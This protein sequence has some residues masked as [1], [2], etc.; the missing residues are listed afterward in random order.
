MLVLLFN[1]P[2]SGINASATQSISIGQSASAAVTVQASAS[3]SLSIGQ[4]ATASTG[5]TVQTPT[6]RTVFVSA[7]NRIVKVL[8]ETRAAIAA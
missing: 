4:V 7:E 6:E 8:A 2:S 3:Q 5:G 1:Q